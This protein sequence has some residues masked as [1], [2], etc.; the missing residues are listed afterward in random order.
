MVTRLILVR[1]GRTDEQGSYCGRGCDPE[2]NEAGRRQASVLAEAFRGV[3]V[4]AVYSSALRRARQTAE[5]ILGSLSGGNELDV[6]RDSR[7][8]EMDFGDW[9]GLT[10]DEIAE[11]WKVEYD[12]W[13]ADPLSV[14]PPGGETIPEVQSRSMAALSDILCDL[15][16][17][18]DAGH[19][20]MGGGIKMRQAIVVSH[21]GTIRLILGTLLKTPPAEYWRITIDTASLSAVDFFDADTAILLYSNRDAI[22]GL[23]REDE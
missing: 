17:P 12:R 3:S 20:S 6:R 19:V 8:D 22:C 7:L 15:R 13:L 10:Y 9:D 4:S 2:L 1:H 21:A 23:P 18:K 14:R 5:A 16:R 11:R